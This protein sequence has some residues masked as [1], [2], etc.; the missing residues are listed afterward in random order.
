MNTI[1]QLDKPIRAVTAVGNLLIDR[2]AKEL[3]HFNAFNASVEEALEKQAKLKISQIYDTLLEKDKQY[4]KYTPKNQREQE[5][6]YGDNVMTTYHAYFAITDK[7]SGV[8]K[9]VFRII[10]SA[11][12]Q[13]QNK[14]S[15]PWQGFLSSRTIPEWE[16]AI[17]NVYNDL[18]NMKKTSAETKEL[19]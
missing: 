1:E 16:E 18:V 14:H 17:F 9:F 6:S 2:D 8:D 7:I 3:L 10:K 11:V 5:D 19:F 4:K 15:K 13:M 12:S